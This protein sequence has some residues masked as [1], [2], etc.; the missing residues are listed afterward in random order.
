MLVRE[1]SCFPF[2]A[3]NL[4]S[5]PEIFLSDSLPSILQSIILIISPSSPSPFHPIQFNS[6][7]QFS[8]DN[9]PIRRRRY[10]IHRYRTLRKIQAIILRTIQ[11]P[12]FPAQWAKQS[13]TSSRRT[14]LPRSQPPGIRPGKSRTTACPGPCGS[15]RPLVVADRPVH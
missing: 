4:T 13:S 1:T 11:T 9:V 12:R 14:S 3:T 6:I 8:Y 15:P 10:A 2:W 7:Q 5:A